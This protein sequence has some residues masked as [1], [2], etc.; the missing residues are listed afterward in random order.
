LKDDAAEQQYRAIADR[1]HSSFRALFWNEDAGCLFDVIDGEQRDGRIRPNQIL[2][3]SLSYPIAPKDW[4][5]PILEA[6]ERELLTPRGI[7]SLAPSDPAY[8]PHYS[9]GV[10]ERDSAYHQGTV[11]SWLMGPFITAYMRAHKYS[12]LAR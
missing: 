5:E 6:V 12:D 7:R 10:W 3:L 1:A 8:R 2:A 11:W 4:A 9:R